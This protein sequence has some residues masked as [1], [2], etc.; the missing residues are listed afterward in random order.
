[1]NMYIV[2]V[3]NLLKNHKQC[4]CTTMPEICSQFSNVIWTYTMMMHN[5]GSISCHKMIVIIFHGIV[6]SIDIEKI[7]SLIKQRTDTH[8]L[9]TTRVYHIRYILHGIYLSCVVWSGAAFFW[10]YVKLNCTLHLV[11]SQNLRTITLSGSHMLGTHF[12]MCTLQSSYTW[13]KLKPMGAIFPNI[14]MQRSFWHPDDDV[15][16]LYCIFIDYISRHK[17]IQIHTKI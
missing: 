1:M 8:S 10:K 2:G 15:I 11:K 4:K 12:Y 7:N 5:I 14:A 13:N 6:C 3:I 9:V 16:V 17:L